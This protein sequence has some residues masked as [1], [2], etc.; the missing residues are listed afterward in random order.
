MNINKTEDLLNKKFEFW[1]EAT[2]MTRYLYVFLGGAIV[3]YFKL[4][5][6]IVA[7]II[8]LLINLFCYHKMKSILNKLIELKRS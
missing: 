4:D 1:D 2:T 8:V 3:S 7:F 6:R 5:F